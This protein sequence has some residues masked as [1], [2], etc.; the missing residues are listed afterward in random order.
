MKC[1]YQ[2]SNSELFSFSFQPIDAKMYILL[3]GEHALIIDPCIDDDALNLLR[4]GNV[5]DIIILPT[6]EHYDHISGIYWLREHFNCKV[7]AIEECARNLDNVKLNISSRFDILFIFEPE[8]IQKQVRALN[9]QPYTCYADEVFKDHLS[10]IW[11]EHSVEIVQTPGHSQ[12]SV[13]IKIDKKYVFTGDSYIFGLPTI[14]RLPGGN[15]KD[16]QNITHPFLDSLPKDTIIFPGHGEW[17]LLN[18]SQ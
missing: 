15:K 6:H 1:I 18:S 13:C 10:F 11:Q 9:I 3:S 12:G 8:E 17:G 14:T 5:K 7:I 2:I 4:K 16:F